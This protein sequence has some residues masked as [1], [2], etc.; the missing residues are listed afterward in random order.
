MKAGLDA[1]GI[2]LSASELLALRDGALRPGRHRPASRRPG[3]LPAKPAGAGMDL[4]EIRAFT[5]GDDARRIDPAATARTGTPH[6]RSF[7]EDRDDTVL[8]IADFRPLMLWGTGDTLRSVRAARALA[9]HGWRALARGASVAAIGVDTAGVALVTSGAGA[10]HM[11]RIAHMLAAGHDRALDA[12]GEAPSLSE[13][14]IRAARLA[15]PGGEVLVATSAEGVASED[16]PPL[17]RLA[18]RRRVRLLLPLDPIDTEPPTRA[19][20]IQLGPLCR[21]ARLQPLDTLAL[22]R[23]LRALNVSLELVAD[24]AG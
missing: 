21:L 14:L 22:A 11:S 4:R 17:A 8:L 5:E 18:R 6:I 12:A 24:D 1:P 3:A 13:A 23:R 19:L 2:R 15:P 9:R 10:Q 7:H 16:E 20:P